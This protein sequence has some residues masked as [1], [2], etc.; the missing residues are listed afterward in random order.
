MDSGKENDPEVKGPEGGPG[1]I[2]PLSR[3]SVLKG[4]GAGALALGSS[5][6]LEACTKS[7]KGSGSSS[8]GKITIGFV[9]PQTG[10][11]AGFAAGDAFVVD[12]IRKTSAYKNGF[13]VGGKTY[14]V[15]IL[16]KDS[17]SDPNR[18]SQVAQDLVT[19][20]HA[21]LVVTSSTP[22]TTNP[23]ATVCESA[24]VPCVS[25]VVPWEAWY[26]ARQADPKNPKPFKYTT[27]YFFGVESFGGCFIPM[28]DEIP[29]NKIVAG[30]WPN[31]PDGNA[32]RGAWPAM[33]K[34]AGYTIVD[35]G[36]YSDGTTDYTAMISK[37][38]NHDCQIFTNAPL[39]PDF[40]TFWKQASQQGFKPKL[41]TVA[42]VLLFPAD[43]QALGTLAN[44]IATDSWWGPFM[45]YKSS[46]DGMTTQQLANAYQSATGQQWLQ[47]IGSSYSLFEVAKI[48]FEASSD[49]HDKN[50]V[51]EQLF[52]VNYKGMSGPLD[53]RTGPHLNPAD[54]TSPTVPGIAIMNPVGVQWQKSTSGSY[55]FEMV[56]VNNN[57]NPEVPL[58]GQLQPT[59]P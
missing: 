38:K 11:L 30:M 43:V 5:A 54:Q 52:K 37:F 10:S 13:K 45:P 33:A 39:P 48:A 34:S 1:L 55:P 12:E 6:F 27:M 18:A 58:G 51:A 26:F 59:N 50:A 57:L 24:G 19:S 22:E 14:S 9:T 56:V 20:S 44:N 15:D 31:D 3:R 46:L 23:V 17:Q 42:K 28:W 35:G 36:A 4:A 8:A 32:F 2:G 21:D 53:F 49:P 41:A 25:T 7:I 29:T 40:N 16:V 47:S